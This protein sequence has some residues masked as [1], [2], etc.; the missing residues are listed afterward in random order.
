M[1]AL[2][3]RCETRGEQTEKLFDIK[4]ETAMRRHAFSID[5]KTKLNLYSGEINVFL[6]ERVSPE[7]CCVKSGPA[8][9][10]TQVATLL[11]CCV[12]TFCATAVVFLVRKPTCAYWLG[13]I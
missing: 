1:I 12:T 3:K 2:A 11:V 7:M 10:M 9:G 5:L 4:G 8:K 6:C 13:A